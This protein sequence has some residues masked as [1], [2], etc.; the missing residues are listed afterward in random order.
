M[1]I[2][3][4]TKEPLG[5]TEVQKDYD[6]AGFAKGKKKRTLEFFD[7]QREQREKLEQIQKKQSQ[8]GNVLEEIKSETKRK[9]ILE[10]AKKVSAD[11]VVV[12]KNVSNVVLALGGAIAAAVT[13]LGVQK[14]VKIK[15]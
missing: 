11:A 13:F 4:A 5:I 1:Y 6:K 8:L 7:K 15:K 14:A 12:A 2:N 10:D 9:N 3:M